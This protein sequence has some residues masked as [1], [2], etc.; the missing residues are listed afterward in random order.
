MEFILTLIRPFCFV[1]ASLALIL[2]NAFWVAAEFSIVRSRRTRLEEMAGQGHESAKN[3]IVIIDG[4]SN[5]LAL[6]QVGITIASLAVGWLAES[7]VVQVLQVLHPQT[8]V[9][10]GYH[11]FAVGIAFVVVTILHVLLG[12]QVPKLLAVRNAERYLLW[13]AGP[14]RFS[15]FIFNP[16][17]RVLDVASTWILRH[18]GHGVSTHSPLSEGELKLILE[19]SHE[20]GVVTDGEAEIIARAFEFA[21]KQTEAVMV[22][23]E[24]VSYI[25]L[26][27]S[28]EQNLV[29]A[30]EHLHSRL[31]VCRE[32][33]DTIVGT[34]SMKDVWPLLETERSNA[35]F[36]RACKRPIFIPIDYS[37][38]QILV[39]F[40]NAHVQI[41]IVRDRANQ[42][43]LG[44]VTLED[45]LVSLVGD[46]REA[47]RG[48]FGFQPFE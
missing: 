41:G 4:I 44:I 23:A 31:P 24:R 39:A 1:L 36:E 46:V 26:G 7:A 5:Y 22:P 11:T 25:S 3:A 17:L 29:V 19:D 35:V 43:T 21:D 14:L 12:E 27:K 42:K 13:M 10:A 16:I 28:L 20:D 9:S 30:K 40:R 45:I 47:K 37:Q 33:L 2:L 38:D 15:H 32:G 48:L 34:V 8:S 6:T 18:L